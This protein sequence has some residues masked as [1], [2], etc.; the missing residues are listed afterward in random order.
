MGIES[1][2]HV[3]SCVILHIFATA[4]SEKMQIVDACLSRFVTHQSRLANVSHMTQ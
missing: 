1:I 4:K 2:T 3:K